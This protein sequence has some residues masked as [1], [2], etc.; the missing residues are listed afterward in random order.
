[1]ITVK[2]SQ[3]EISGALKNFDKYNKATQANITKGIEETTV[4]V[5]R[6]AKQNAPVDTGRLRADIQ[7]TT[8]DR[9]GEVYNTVNYAPFVELGTSRMNAAPYMFPAWEAYRLAFIMKMKRAMQ[10]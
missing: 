7:F 5:D 1:M 10:L 3:S 6:R 9:R 2:I 4:N 8:T